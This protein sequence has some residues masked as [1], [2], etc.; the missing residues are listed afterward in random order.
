MTTLLRPQLSTL[1]FAIAVLHAALRFGVIPYFPELQASYGGSNA[2]IG[3]LYSAY[4]VTFTLLQLP[5]G[6]LADRRPPGPLLT[7]SLLALAA[8]TVLFALS[9]AWPPALAAR[10]AM[11][12]AG[13]AIFPVVVHLIY[14]NTPPNRHAGLF[15]LFD[16]GIATA[17]LLT[18]S[19]APLFTQWLSMSGLHLAFAAYALVLI[20]LIRRAPAI[21]RADQAARAGNKPQRR[22]SLR[23]PSPYAHVSLTRRIVVV[24]GLI[25]LVNL[26]FSS[27]MTWLPSYLRLEQG[28]SAGIAGL[29]LGALTA[30]NLLFSYLAG[31]WANSFARFP[32]IDAGT[33]LMLGGMLALLGSDASVSAGWL[34]LVSGL[35]GIGTALA[36][37][38]TALVI[39]DLFGP[40]RAGLSAALIGITSQISYIASGSLMGWLIDLSGDF[41]L[42]WLS[43]ALCLLVRLG[44][45]R[46][47]TEVIPAGM[48]TPA[49]LANALGTRISRLQTRI[50]RWVEK[51][52]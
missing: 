21:H 14:R 16:A 9:R 24:I 18:L 41:T 37:T 23:P 42:I 2:Q 43:G 40:Q 19:I 50:R 6:Y 1:I 28:S 52:P 36:Y 5:A 34:F 10:F 33:L 29:I 30:S 49:D 44:A 38:P 25:F 47:L 3:S 31:R 8:A 13:A 46:L 26:P 4:F 48:R 35:I 32:I 39:T 11:G 51:E 15:G 20:V 45:T 17:M 22:H 12:A 27:I 7:F